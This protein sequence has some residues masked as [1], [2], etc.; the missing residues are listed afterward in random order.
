MDGDSS[1]DDTANRNRSEGPNFVEA[2]PRI[3]AD[4]PFCVVVITVSSKECIPV[5]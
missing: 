3:G 4:M 2:Y 1:D 5:L